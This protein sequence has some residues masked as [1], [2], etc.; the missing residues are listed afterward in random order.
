MSQAVFCIGNLFGSESVKNCDIDD[1]GD[2][3]ENKSLLWTVKP[4]DGWTRWFDR[5]MEPGIGSARKRI[6]FEFH[7]LMHI[8]T[9]NFWQFLALFPADIVFV[10][11]KWIYFHWVQI[12]A[13]SKEWLSFIY[14]SILNRQKFEFY[15][16]SQPMQW[17]DLIAPSSRTEFPMKI[18]KISIR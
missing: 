3:F 5:F 9:C 17:T 7:I 13:W 4:S 8:F 6:I 14:T 11:F 15:N 18:E 16:F 10:N 1:V 12:F 2:S